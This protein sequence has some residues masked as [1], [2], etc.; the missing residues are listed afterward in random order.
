M[1]N[2]NYYFRAVELSDYIKD[3]ESYL[4]SFSLI[5]LL[6]GFFIGFTF[7]YGW[8]RFSVNKYNQENKSE[9]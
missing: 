1:D 3:L 9:D 7:C 6:A 5:A 2:I 4:I 8:V